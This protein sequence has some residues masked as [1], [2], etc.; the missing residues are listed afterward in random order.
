VS[1]IRQEYDGSVEY[2]EKMA[3]ESIRRPDDFGY[4]GYDDMFVT[5]GFSGIDLTRDATCLDKANWEAFHRDIVTE[6]PDDFRIENFGHW[7]VGSVDRTIVR[8]LNDEAA[9]IAYDNIT[10][11]FIHTLSIHDAIREYCV[12]DESLLSEEE[13]QANISWI[14]WTSNDEQ[15]KCVDIVDSS[16]YEKWIEGLMEI[17]AYMSPDADEYPDKDQML[18]AAH[19]QGMWSKDYK[20]FWVEYCN[21]QDLEVPAIFK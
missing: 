17:D 5:W 7:A 3:T 14:E 21:K 11:A 13:F 12:L 10:D 16:S 1:D 2:I 8:V 4:W 9:G 18:N 20:E 19:Y 6:Y 15:F